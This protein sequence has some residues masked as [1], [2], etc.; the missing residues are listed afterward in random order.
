MNRKTIVIVLLLFSLALG[1]TGIFLAQDMPPLPGEEILSGLGAVRGIEFDAEGNLFVAEAG[2]GGETE[3]SMMGPEGPADVSAGLSGK[4]IM[5]APDG[6]ASDFLGGLPSYAFPT[7]TLGIYRAIPNGDSLWLIYSGDGPGTSGRY[8][9]DSIV[10]LDMESLATLTLI[11]LNAYELENDPDG[12][13][14][15][16]NVVDIDWLS[17]GTMLIVD[18]GCNCLLSWTEADGLATVTAWGN[19]VPTSIDVA[20]NDDVYVGF[21]GEG[22]AP[23]AGKIE[24]WSGGEVVETFGGLTG[25]TDVLVDGENLYAVQLFLFGEEGPG[26]GN[27]VMVTADGATP[28]AEGLIAPFGIAMSPDGEL[29]VSWGTIAFAPGMTGGVVKIAQ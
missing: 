12:L 25:V 16:S 17:D 22:I 24:H 10:E 18:S 2:T 28:I 27:V 21:L 3:L 5:V 11:N 29:Y 23:G 8:W 1:T 13:G 6:T 19:D 9:A 14:Y 26:P 7:E 15:D 4:I 20:E